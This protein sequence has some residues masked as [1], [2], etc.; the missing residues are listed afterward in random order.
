MRTK[1]TILDFYKMSEEAPECTK[2]GEAQ[3]VSAKKDFSRG[4]MSA[5]V[6]IWKCRAHS[7]N[8]NVRPRSQFYYGMLHN[9]N[10][11]KDTQEKT[12]A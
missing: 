11:C 9:H 8:L 10:S 6:Q 12:V 2:N 7:V 3:K 1:L 4:C 5:Q